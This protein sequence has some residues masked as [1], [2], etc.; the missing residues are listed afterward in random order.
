MTTYFACGVEPALDQ[1][2]AV[3]IREAELDLPD[4]HGGQ[5]IEQIVDVEADL[6]LI[7]RVSDLELLLGLFLLGIM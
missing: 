7:A 4:I 3:A 2:A 6:E 1:A 5:R